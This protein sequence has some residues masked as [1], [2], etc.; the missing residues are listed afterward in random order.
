VPSWEDAAAQIWLA[1]NDPVWS[2][3]RHAY[4]R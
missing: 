1:Y 4:S 3:A 2:T